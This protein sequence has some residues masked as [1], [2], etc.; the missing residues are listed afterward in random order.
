MSTDSGSPIAQ[1][2]PF[3]IDLPRILKMRIRLIA[4]EPP[5]LEHFK[6]SLS[7]FKQAIEFLVE[8]DG[9]IPVRDYGPALFVGDVE[10]HESERL[11]EKAWRFL[12]FHPKMLKRGAPISWGWMKDP[13]K[14]RLHTPFK[15]ELEGDK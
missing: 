13:K 7:R 6:S 12:E 11:G 15:Y 2:P 8:T 3:P 4:F 14:R 10:V 9:P 5:Q 1:R